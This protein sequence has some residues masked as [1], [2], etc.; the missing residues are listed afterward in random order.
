[1]LNR[2]KLR[3][4]NCLAALILSS[5]IVSHGVFAQG[6]AQ[7]GPANLYPDP[8]LTP[9][10]A[11]TLSLEDLTARYSDHCPKHKTSCTYS[12]DHRNV[13]TEEHLQAYDE[14]RVPQDARNAENGEVDHFYPLCAGGSNDISNLWYQPADNQWNGQNLGY[15]QKDDLEAW[16]CAQIKKHA[17]D[18]Q[19]FYKR[20]TTDWVAYYLEVKPPHSSEGD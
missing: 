10:K 18:P 8:S 20:I 14:Y 3:R 4:L 6:A 19:E 9:G 17:L 15:H 12:E 13:S 7:A 11:A 2:S 1:M 16:G 5:F